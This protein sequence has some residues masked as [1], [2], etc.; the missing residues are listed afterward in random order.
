MKREM[1]CIYTFK[2]EQ[3]R[4]MAQLLQHAASVMASTS[5]LKKGW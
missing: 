2:L 4:A 5:C 1:F 3:F